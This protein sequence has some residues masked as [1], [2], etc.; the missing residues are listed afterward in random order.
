MYDLWGCELKKAR[1][2]EGF[3]QLLNFETVQK[4]WEKTPTTISSGF[5]QSQDLDFHSVMK[6]S[7]AIS[8]EIVKE[9]LIHTMML[10]VVENAGA[11]NATLLLR[12]KGL[13]QWTARAEMEGKKVE[14]FEDDFS[15]ITDERLPLQVLQY[16]LRTQKALAIHHATED[17][18]CA[19][20][21]YV[22]KYQ[23]ESLL[24]VPI[25]HRNEVT[26]LLYMENNL[27]RN[28][29]TPERIEII[30]LLASQMVISM[31]NATLY[32]E[33]EARVAERTHKLHEANEKLTLLATLDSLTGAYNRRHFIEVANT[34]M[35]RSMRS[36]RPLGI[37]MIDIDH[38]K[39]IND[40]YGHSA[41][42][43][44]LK[45]VVK[46]CLDTLRP[47]DIFGRLGGEEFAV[48]LPDTDIQLCVNVAER[49]RSSVEQLSIE[50]P[51]HQ[52]SVTLSI[53]VCSAT[54]NDNTLEHLL[55]IADQGLYKAKH[56]GRNKVVV[57][58]D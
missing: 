30:Q 44:A 50:S 29:F 5:T 2:S 48:I 55:H 57:S 10:L 9:K 34:E 53:G 27:L 21:A 54:G 49:L 42:D 12:N 18:L 25:L 26:G 14:L 43:E 7:Q 51:P 33:L 52:F 36:G 58:K 28:A 4:T 40:S 1:L 3:Q 6:A 37:M 31:D 15:F 46:T 11:Q 47:G 17:P 38:F 16:V 19:Q 45:K 32:A 56:E 24:C 13:W 22:V 20:D 39:M 8:G 23:P 35:S 41:G